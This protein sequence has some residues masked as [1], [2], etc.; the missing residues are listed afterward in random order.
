MR[1]SSV[2][3][4]GI[5]KGKTSQSVE[6]TWFMHKLLEIGFE[7]A[8]ALKRVVQ[9]EPENKRITQKGA[10]ERGQLI[11]CSKECS[12]RPERGFQ[13]LFGLL[14]LIYYCFITKRSLRNPQVEHRLR[15]R[16]QGPWEGSGTTPNARILWSRGKVELSQGKGPK[17]QL[18][19]TMNITNNYIL[20]LFLE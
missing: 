20:L 18:K 15:R 6:V 1:Q 17:S 12:K 7:W 13:T 11:R 9:R 19:Q 8:W 16:Q 10:P 14:P 3:F 5:G 4:N 2:N